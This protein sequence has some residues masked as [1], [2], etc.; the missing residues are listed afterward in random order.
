MIEAATTIK[1]ALDSF[2]SSLDADQ[3][4]RFNRLDK[5]LAKSG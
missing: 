3:K 2:Y 4:A 5:S 1:P